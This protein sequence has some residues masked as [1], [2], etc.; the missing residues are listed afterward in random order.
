[1]V[2]EDNNESTVANAT[3]KQ[4]SIKIYDNNH[5]LIAIGMNTTTITNVIAVKVNKI[6]LVA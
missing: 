2:N 1:M 4:N 3:V 5:V 6:Y